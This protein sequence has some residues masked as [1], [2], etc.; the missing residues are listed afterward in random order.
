[1]TEM[2]ETAYIVENATKKSLVIIDELGRGTSTHDGLAIAFAVCEELI[3][4]RSLVFFA[5]HFQELTST[6]T[7]YHNVV[8]L[9]L[10][11]EM[12]RDEGQKPGISY[13]YRLVKGSA[14]EEHYGLSLAKTLNLPHDIL[15]RA[16]VVSIRLMDLQES[17]RR[18]SES[19]RIVSRRRALAQAA[20][21]CV[22]IQEAAK[23]MTDEELVV[24]LHDVQQT[25][26][27]HLLAIPR[28]EQDIDK[29][30]DKDKGKSAKRDSGVVMG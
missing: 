19:N 3:H 15:T 4:N 6:L 7:A 25:A 14:K 24:A 13:K 23:G 8:N 21:D 12:T 18:H 29:D 11:T 5:T 30:K 2:K 20:H 26:M 16:E 28:E 9:H 22:L 27:R 1:M 10:E 17:A